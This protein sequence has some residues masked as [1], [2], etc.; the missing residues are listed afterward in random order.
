MTTGLSA[1][2]AAL[3]H[4]LRGG[5]EDTGDAENPVTHTHTHT[6]I[7][8]VSRLK[9]SCTACRSDLTP[10]HQTDLKHFHHVSLKINNSTIIA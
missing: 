8:E 6:R 9:L 1:P 2:V 5:E 10:T 7:L 3:V 4:G